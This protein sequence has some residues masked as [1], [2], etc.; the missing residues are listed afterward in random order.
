VSQFALSGK[1][2]FLYPLRVSSKITLD[3]LKDVQ[4]HLAARSRA[5]SSR[6]GAM[7]PPPPRTLPRSSNPSPPKDAASERTTR[8]MAERARAEALIARRLAAQNASSSVGGDTPISVRDGGYS[9][10]YNKRE[11]RAAH[12]A[13]ERQRG[14]HGD[15]RWDD[16]T[17]DRQWDRGRRSE[18]SSGRHESR[19]RDS[20]DRSRERERHKDMPRGDRNRTRGVEDVRRR[21]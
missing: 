5:L 18:S 6:T 15:R 7:P 4:S 10:G 2:S 8:E 3:P 16:D 9:D 14:R 13:W 20:R 19:S 1:T 21:S 11:T 17:E 12:D